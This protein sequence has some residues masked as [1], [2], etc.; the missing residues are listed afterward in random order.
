[1]MGKSE[2]VAIC[3]G[4]RSTYIDEIADPQTNQSVI[5]GMLLDLRASVSFSGG[6]KCLPYPQIQDYS[7]VKF[8]P[9]HNI[10]NISLLKPAS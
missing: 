1:M 7:D 9:K 6:H 5:S 4:G 8:F 2:W 10:K 3:C